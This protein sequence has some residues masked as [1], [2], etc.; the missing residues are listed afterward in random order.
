VSDHPAPTPAGDAGFGRDRR[1]RKRREF[2]HVYAARTFIRVGPLVVYARPGPASHARLGLSVPRR[3]GSAVRRNRVK[4]RLR[5]AFRLGRRE[6][7]GAY[8]VVVNVRPHDPL[9]LA[10][11]QRELLRALRELHRR[12]TK[13]SDNP[14]PPPA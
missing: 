13:R 3:V 6:L 7:P 8:D 1:L 4:R 10:S 12:W 11:Y 14:A 2:E 5:E 9:P